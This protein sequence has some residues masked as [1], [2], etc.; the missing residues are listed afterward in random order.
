MKNL[1]SLLILIAVLSACSTSGGVYK[2]DDP[3]NGEFSAK[4]TVLTVIGVIGAAL[5]MKNNS[6][7]DNNY[8][9]PYQ[10]DNG[11]DNAI[12][13]QTPTPTQTTEKI[14]TSSKEAQLAELQRLLDNNLITKE[15]YF[16]RQNEILRTLGR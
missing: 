2:K 4:K 1:I 8:Y 16:E 13:T 10:Y 6:N 15:I 3:S 5:L 9:M 7:Y 11:A 12:A 14:T